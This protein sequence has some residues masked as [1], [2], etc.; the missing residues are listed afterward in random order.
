M[1]VTLSKAKLEAKSDAKLESQLL[2]AIGDDDN[3]DVEMEPVPKTQPKLTLHEILQLKKVPPFMASFTFEH[4]QALSYNNE[5]TDSLVYEQ[6]AAAYYENMGQQ[7]RG[8]KVSV[9]GMRITF[10]IREE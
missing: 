2:N 9:C 4:V 3:S 8:F 6:Q 10:V 7:L 5:A 1:E